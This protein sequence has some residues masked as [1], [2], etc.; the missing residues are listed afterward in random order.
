MRDHADA[1]ASSGSGKVL[2]RSTSSTTM[3]SWLVSAYSGWAGGDQ[4]RP[5]PNWSH[6]RRS[7]TSAPPV[8]LQPPRPPQPLHSLKTSPAALEAAKSTSTPP[9]ATGSSTCW[10]SGGLHGDGACSGAYARSSGNSPYCWKRTEPRAARFGRKSLLSPV[11]MTRLSE[12]NTQLTDILCLSDMTIRSLVH[13]KTSVP[14]SG[15][16]S[17]SCVPCA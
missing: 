15:G 8:P 16:S 14:A 2:C 10:T 1:P 13:D 3:S 4:E 9:C 11:D 12:H 6:T 5:S 17:S 7:P